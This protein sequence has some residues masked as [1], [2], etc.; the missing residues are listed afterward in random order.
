[1]LRHWLTPLPLGD[2][3]A[4]E[5]GRVPSAR[6]GTAAAALGFFDWSVLDRVLAADPAPD[7]LVASQ[8]R[9]VDVPEPRSTSDVRQLM[10][11]GLGVVVRKTERHDP[12]LAELARCFAE[13]LPGEVHV[14]LYITPAGTRTFGWHYDF[15]DVFIVQ[16]AGSKDYYFRDNTV[17]RDVPA[18]PHPDFSAVR[19][20]TSPLYSSRLIAGDFLYIPRRWWHL[21]HSVEDAL[22]ISIG[23]IPSAALSS[24]AARHSR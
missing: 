1:M 21:V 9:L 16:T 12:A 23:V 11:R 17:A 18:G 10:Q 19:R 15:E 13:D 14:Q 3:I 2:F 7:V 5:L 20:E 22:S 6:P 24:P 4:R 8:G